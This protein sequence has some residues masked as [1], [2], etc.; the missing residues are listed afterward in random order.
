MDACLHL[1][2]IEGFGDE[3]FGPRLQ[4]AQFVARLRGDDQHRH[5]T[6]SFD[7]PQGVHDLESIHVRHLQIEQNQVVVMRQV[8]GA[9]GARI[10]GCGD[11]LVAGTAQHLFQQNDVRFLVINDQD[12]GL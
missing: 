11:A 6:I 10:H 8:Q 7:F 4:R 5:I 3:V 2:Q 9:D 1:D 12:A